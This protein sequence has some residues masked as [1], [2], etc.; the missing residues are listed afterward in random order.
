MIYTTF[1]VIC[2]WGCLRLL[3]SHRRVLSAQTLSLYYTLIHLLLIDSAIAGALVIV[4]NLVKLVLSSPLFNFQ[5][6]NSMAMVSQMLVS[7]VYPLATNAILLLYVRP[8]RRAILRLVWWRRGGEV[9]GQTQYTEAA[10]RQS[11]VAGTVGM[12]S[13]ARRKT[14]I[15]TVKQN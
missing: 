10:G 8:Y 14:T 9:Q 12:F 3:V 4:P 1:L 11:S 2:T 15:T 6:V 5:A 13:P 7:S